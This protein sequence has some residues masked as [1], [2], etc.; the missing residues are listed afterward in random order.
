MSSAPVVNRKRRTRRIP[1]TVPLEVSGKDVQRCTF[2]LTTTATSLNRNGASLHLNR[3]LAVGS[4]V[5][6]QNSR[7]TRSSVR[8]VTQTIAGDGVYMYGV[9]FLEEADSGKD[10]WGISFP[11]PS[12]GRRPS[13][14]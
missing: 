4:V 5:V 13:T 1:L 12:Q 14:A 10:F 11:A 8:I 2:T 3:D 6:V 9:E 7:G